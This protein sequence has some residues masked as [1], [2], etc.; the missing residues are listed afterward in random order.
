MIIESML[1]IFDAN[2]LRLYN[3]VVSEIVCIGDKC[4]KSNYGIL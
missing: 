1:F 2:R 4:G 3:L